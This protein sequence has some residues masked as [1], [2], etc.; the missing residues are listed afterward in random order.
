LPEIGGDC[1]YY[2]DD[3]EPEQMAKVTRVGLLDFERDKEN[4]EQQIIERA[5][6]FNWETCSKKY[7]DLYLKILGLNRI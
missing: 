7:I 5:R 3:L 6:S 1:A 2:Y 4:K